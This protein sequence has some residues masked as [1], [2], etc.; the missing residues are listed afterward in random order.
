[1]PLLP[2]CL[3]RV[4]G[5]ESPRGIELESGE[6]WFFGRE[7]L[8][9]RMEVEGCLR[10]SNGSR[11]DGFGDLDELF[12]PLV[13]LQMMLTSRWRDLLDLILETAT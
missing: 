4:L 11:L 12:E 13:T 1:M 3:A 6:I 5:T 8:L 9:D 2:R 10:S 7:D